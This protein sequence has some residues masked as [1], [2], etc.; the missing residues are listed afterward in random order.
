MVSTGVFR[1]RSLVTSVVLTFFIVLVRPAVS[2]AQSITLAWDPNTEPSVAGYMVYGGTESGNYTQM[3]DAGSQTTIQVTAIDPAKNNYFA[4]RA[5]TVDGLWS[6]L[7]N[8]VVLPAVAPANTTI[9]GLNADMAYPLL[10]GTP[11]TWTAS[12]S[13][14]VGPVE[15][16]FLLYRQQT[17]WVVAQDYSANQTFSWTPGWNDLGKAA[18]QVWARPVGS[19]EPYVAWRGTDPFDV[20]GIPVTLSADTDFPSPPGQPVRWT[21]AVAGATGALQYKFLLLNQA[22]G[23]W[24]VLRDYDASN[25]VTWIPAS[26]GRYAVQVWARRPGSAAPYELWTG[27]G[28]LDIAPTPLSVTALEADTTFPALTGAPITWT[29][30]TRG[31]TAGPLQF[32]FIRYSV[33]TGK[34]L[35]MQDYSTSRTFTWKPTWGD[36]GTYA[37]QVWARSAGS[38]ANMDAWLSTDYFEIRR[39]PLQLS[40]SSELPA[41]PQ[42]PITWTTSAS[43]P[44]LS[45][46]YAYFVYSREKGTWAVGRPYDPSS[47]F[48]WTPETSGTY[49]LQVWARRAGSSASYDMWRGTDLFNIFSSPAHMKSLA[50]DVALPAPVN[51]PITW[52]AVANGGTKTPLQYRFVVYRENVGWRVLQEYS[53]SNT[54]VWTPGPGEAGRYALQV[55]VRSAGSA[56]AYEDW[57]G[58]P[59]F[60]IQP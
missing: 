25:Q 40:A 9:S 38:P 7:S 31:G 49:A 1:V 12:A 11:V 44:S 36:E 60:V 52:T 10:V 34:W 50:A 2:S 59:Y 21:A 22:T 45:L 51:T 16:K 29:A 19:T 35:V 57:L 33:N 18:V 48:T 5:Y 58:T 53:S 46:E 32:K 41:P 55:W 42:S 56:A 13:S 20:K 3:I 23:I 14:T 24:T 15:Y 4:V 26:V 27:T 28:V 37:L 8:E 30:R 39:A 43:D 47:S 54:L 17:G 6:G